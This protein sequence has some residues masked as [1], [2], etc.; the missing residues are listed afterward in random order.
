MEFMVFIVYYAISINIIKAYL[1]LMTILEIFEKSGFE[2]YI[3]GG[4][5]RD[6]IMGKPPY[7]YDVCTD[8]TPEQIIEVA[9]INNIHWI[10]TGIDHGT[11]TLLYNN[12][13][14]QV[15]TYRKDINCNGRHA[16][17]EW[18]TSLF[19]DLSRRDFTINAMA[20]NKENVLFDPFNGENDIKN[21]I[22]QTVG[23]PQ[24][25]FDEDKLR[26]LRAIRFAT[27]LSFK[28]EYNTWLEILKTDI[29]N[30][31]Q[32]RIRDEFI[33]IIMS[34]NRVNGLKLLDN[35]KLLKQFIPEFEA[36]KN[37]KAGDND[38]HP[39]KDVWT[40]T[41]AA[42]SKLKKG[43]SLELILGTLFHDIGKPVTWDS[44]R[45]HGH[46]DIGAEMTETILRRM[47]FSID[48]IDKVKWLVKNHMR[49]HIFNE[50]R[51]AKK[52]RLIQHPLF[53]ELIKLLTADIMN[54][55]YK[56][57]DDIQKFKS[58]QWHKNKLKPPEKFIDGYDIL[59]I[60]ILPGPRIAEIRTE[61]EDLILEGSITNREQALLYL[62]ENYKI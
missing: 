36:M 45:F 30:I 5:V 7:D 3:V 20:M 6:I 51:T 8:A 50:M 59:A 11:I 4:A 17:V 25:R 35:S 58:A 13:E 31:S 37:I 41:I 14:F 1:I 47:K 54:K 21:K 44:Y 40:H 62:Q 53:S 24:K 29:S 19:D 39:E 49:I 46:N 55:D 15:T 34:P 9:D 61:V 32:E 43:A 57:L 60:G 12:Q 42:L 16:V 18:S 33:K 22:I 2:A 48:T 38:H 56:I 52:I 23:N 26:A 27:T 28:I 10:P